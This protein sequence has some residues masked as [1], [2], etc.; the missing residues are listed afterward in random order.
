SVTALLTIVM[1]V[2]ENLHGVNS[3]IVGL[4]PVTI[5]LATG[6]VTTKEFRSL[7]WDV[8]WLVAGGIALGQAVGHTGFDAW[9]VGL[10]DWTSLSTIVVGGLMA[11]AALVLSTFIS[12]SAATNLLAPMAIAVAVSTNSGPVAA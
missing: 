6:V 1:W 9:V 3:Y 12:N 5:L 8:L 10:V 4:I 11:L 7:E 2:T